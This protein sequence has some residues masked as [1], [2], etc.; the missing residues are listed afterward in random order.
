MSLLKKQK[1]LAE[2]Q[3]EDETLDTEISVSRK[4]LMLKR[5]DDKLGKGGWKMFSSNGKIA[6]IDWGKVWVWLK[7]N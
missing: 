2:L 4:R 1:T 5:L 7:N 3:E 6:G